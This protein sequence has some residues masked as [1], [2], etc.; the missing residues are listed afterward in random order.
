MSHTVLIADQRVKVHG[1]SNTTITTDVLDKVLEFGPFKEW[2]AR[3]EKAQRERNSEMDILSVEIQ[4]TDMFGSGKLG[5]V[6]FKADVRYKETGKSAPGIVFLRGGSVSMLIILRCP[7]KEDQILLTLQPRVP[8]ASLEFPELPAGM[9][10]GSGNFAGTAAR[11]IYEE[12]GLSIQEHELV[13]LT[14]KAYGDRWQGMYP[15][16]GGCDEFV[17]LFMCIKHMARSDIEALEGKLG[18]LRDRG[19]NITLK[20][21][22]L[23]D[24]W[25]IAPDA[26]LL[27]TLTL[28]HA[29][30][31]S[32]TEL[33]K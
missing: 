30:L 25:K 5:F 28:Y 2:A 14:H 20:L 7:E 9:L 31:Q 29:L 6:K 8:V 24:A 26:K 27:S 33:Q 32:K 16:A 3:M 10:D 21:V 23:K 4:N 11:E 22:S 18:G 1:G 12:T 15:S 13:D 19:E 17:R